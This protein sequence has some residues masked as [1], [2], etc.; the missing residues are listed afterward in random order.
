VCPERAFDLA[1]AVRQPSSPVLTEEDL[2]PTRSGNVQVQW[3]QNEP[4]VRLNIQ[5][6][7]PECKIHDSDNC[8]FRLY[9]GRDSSVYVFKLTPKR[10]G[11]IGITVKLY[12]ENDCLGSTRLYTTVGASGS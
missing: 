2:A 5:I 3:P 6:V 11:K 8:S 9:A 1:V 7:A 12:Q 10:P 4:H